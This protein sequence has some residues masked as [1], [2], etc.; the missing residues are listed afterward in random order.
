MYVLAREREGGRRK[1]REGESECVCMCV[2][3]GDLQLC[4]FV[5]RLPLKEVQPNDRPIY[6][7]VHICIHTQ[8][9]TGTDTERHRHRHTWENGRE[10]A[11]Q[12]QHPR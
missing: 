9:D 8:T 6:A 2:R 7:Y 3:E 4:S 5:V 10:I 1:L 11:L 12:S